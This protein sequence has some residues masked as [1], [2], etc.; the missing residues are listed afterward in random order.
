MLLEK[1]VHKIYTQGSSTGFAFG[2][3][4]MK[5]VI[6]FVVALLFARCSEADRPYYEILSK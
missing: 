5:I 6:V 4:K 1:L 2:K 3:D